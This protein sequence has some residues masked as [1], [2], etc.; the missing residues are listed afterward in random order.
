MKTVLSNL[1]R[2]LR[3]VLVT[4]LAGMLVYGLISVPQTVIPRELFFRDYKPRVDMQLDN[5]RTAAYLRLQ[6]ADVM[7]SQKL[8]ARHLLCV[9]KQSNHYRYVEESDSTFGIS[10]DTNCPPLDFT[11]VEPAGIH[12]E[13]VITHVIEKSTLIG[14]LP[15]HHSSDDRAIMLE[16][17]GG[18]FV[19]VNLGVLKHLGIHPGETE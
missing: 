4:V 9:S 5:R 10:V 17:A 7:F 15:G 6:F 14:V 16:T 11:S 1:L 2:G 13:L 3:A 19:L 12:P 8:N 18:D